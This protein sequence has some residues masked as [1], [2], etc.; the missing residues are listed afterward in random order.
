[1]KTYNKK[2]ITHDTRNVKENHVTLRT[3]GL[4]IYE[5]YKNW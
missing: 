2:G 3:N 5:W 4:K 1:M